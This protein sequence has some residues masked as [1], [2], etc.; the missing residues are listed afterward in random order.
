[1]H[2]ERVACCFA[3]GSGGR[4]AVETRSLV[5]SV[6]WSFLVESASLE[7]P[8][9]RAVVGVSRWLVLLVPPAVLT[10]GGDPFRVATLTTGLLSR[11]LGVL[12]WVH[13]TDTTGGA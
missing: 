13:G 10:P 11:Q 2:F 7:A 12:G 3:D 5:F 8:S 1:M 9:L 4:A 6:T